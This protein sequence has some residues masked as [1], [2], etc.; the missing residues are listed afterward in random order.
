[1]PSAMSR[2][3]HSRRGKLS[4]LR[5]VMMRVNRTIAF[6][7]I[8]ASLAG[9]VRVA[10]AS[11]TG[12]PAADEPRPAARDP[13][14]ARPSAR[15]RGRAVRDGGSRRPVQRG[16]SRGHHRCRQRIGGCDRAR[17]HRHQRFRAGRHQR[18]DPLSRQ[19][20]RAA[21]DQGGLRAVQQGALRHH[22]PQEPRH[23]GAGRYRGQDARRRRGRSVDPAVAGGGRQN[24]I[25]LTNV[26]Q[27]RSAPR[28][29][30]RCCRRARSMPSPDSP[31][32]RRSICRD[33]GVPADDLAVLRFADYGCEAYGF[34][35]IV[36]PALAAA[37][38]EAVKGFVRAMIG[39]THSPSRTRQRAATEVVSRMDGGS[40]ELELERLHS[41][42]P[43]QHPDRRG[44]AQRHRRHR[45]GQLRAL[46]RSDRGGFQI[47]EAA[48][49]LGHF[50]R[51]VPAAAQ[52]PPDQ[53]SKAIRSEDAVSRARIPA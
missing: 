30:S 16:R 38:P 3:R 46:D 8:L 49:G 20:K 23:P 45:P 27:S 14:F 48:A 15:C 41:R 51:P 17:R 35:L 11:A 7:S 52:R 5:D 2:N 1:M 26:K 19:G 47:P 50:R 36:N 53:L 29:A 33:R 31:I 40:R 9:L 34:A 4:R 12:R 22:R 28:C 10:C 24:G 44:Q 37:K 43:R 18:A 6:R 21:A 13:V 39:G 25:K 32:C 42:H